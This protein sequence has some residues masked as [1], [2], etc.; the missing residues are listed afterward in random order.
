MKR[1]PPAKRRTRQREAVRRA[2]LEAARE[3]LV[4]GGYE[5]FSMRKL[6]D[7]AGYSAGAIYLYF[8]T[9]E[10]L[11]DSLVEDAFAKLLEV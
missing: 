4:Q 6:A 8:E 9:K 10:E 3:T 2:I 11:L 1:S 5:T 7:A